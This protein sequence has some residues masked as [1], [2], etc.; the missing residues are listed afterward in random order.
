[1]K[2]TAI[3][4]FRDNYVWAIHDDH[5]VILVD[6]GEA[7]PILAWLERWQRHPV[8]ILVTHHH[9]DHVGGIR[10]ITARYAIP[11]Y[12]PGNEAIPGRTHPLLGG[13]TVQI[14]ELGLTFQVL[15]TPGHTLGHLCYVGH[16]ALFCGDTL[17]SCGCGRLFEGTP[18]QM[19][20][21]LNRIKALPAETLVYCA[22]E[23]TLENLAF[24][25]KVEPN[26]PALQ[27]RLMEVRS[28]LSQEKP[29]LPV[30][31]SRE[32]ATNP[33]LRFDQSSVAVAAAQHAGHPAQP[34][35]VTFTTVRA[36]RDGY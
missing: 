6:P 29:T 22:H 7:A 25:L 17:F 28:L 30:S 36:W 27:T 11:V 14:S 20:A 15:A 19:H 23:Y 34:G 35:L 12:G 33:F 1:M 5:S 4:A 31:L 8:A 10:E 21:S 24:A 16:G 26:N 2:V 9:A 32:I 3:P 13:E 18:A